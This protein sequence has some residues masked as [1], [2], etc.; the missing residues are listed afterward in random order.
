VPHVQLDLYG[1]SGAVAG[2]RL[3]SKETAPPEKQS[4]KIPVQR[5]AGKKKRRFAQEQK[6]RGSGTSGVNAGSRKT[7]HYETVIGPTRGARALWPDHDSK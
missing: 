7:A 6:I 5:A 2:V 3:D 1:F 4:R